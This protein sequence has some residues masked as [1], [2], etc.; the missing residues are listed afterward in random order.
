MAR[1]KYEGLL[2]N[3]GSDDDQRFE[4]VWKAGDRVKYPGIYRCDCGFETVARYGSPFPG[5]F[6][7]N[8]S[9]QHPA[10]DKRPIRWTLIVLASP[11]DPPLEGD[12]RE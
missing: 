1:Y 9:H 10:N 5:E 2:T 3:A 7:T 12:E 4:E 11:H 8:D 6:G